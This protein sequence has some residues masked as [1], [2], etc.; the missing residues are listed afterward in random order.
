MLGMK[1]ISKIGT[2]FAIVFAIVAIFF[3]ATEGLFESAGILF[4]GAPWVFIFGAISFF[5]VQSIGA[6][7]TLLVLP[8]IVNAAIL[9]GLGMLLEW[10]IAD[11]KRR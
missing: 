9:Y 10:Y 11:R 4:M 2:T 6:L 8:L 1:Y 3:I 5:G 7:G